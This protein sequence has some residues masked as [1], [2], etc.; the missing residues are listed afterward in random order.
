VYYAVIK[1]SDDMS[2]AIESNV[3]LPE[4]KKRNSYPYKQMD[5]GDSFF[6]GGAKINI[7]CNNNYRIGKH[8]GMK[9][10]AR[11][12]GDGVRVWRTQ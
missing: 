3:P 1:R 8:T 6:I 9:F 2:I 12:E 11:R 7:V 4:E 10:T 5:V